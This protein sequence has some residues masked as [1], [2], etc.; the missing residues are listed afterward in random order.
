[1][2]ARFRLYHDPKTGNQFVVFARGHVV[3][4]GKDGWDSGADVIIDSMMWALMMGVD[5]PE[6]DAGW[7]E[8]EMVGDEIKFQY[9][10]CTIAHRGLLHGGCTV[11]LVG[12]PTFNEA[13]AA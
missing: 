1:M 7:F 8:A 13:K 2:N 3:V 5:V 12:G 11:F 6:G 9:V 4:P 10:E